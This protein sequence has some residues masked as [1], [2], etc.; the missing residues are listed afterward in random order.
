MSRLT[1]LALA[2]LVLL[3]LSVVFAGGDT[4]KQRFKSNMRSEDS[5]VRYEA[6]RKLDTNDPDAVKAIVKVLK[7]MDPRVT[8]S[9]IRSG[10]VESL[11]KA[12]SEDSLKLILK[13]MAKGKTP[14]REVMTAAIGR[15]KDPAY[16][17]ALRGALNDKQPIVRRAA[18]RAL[19]GMKDKEAI[20]A[21]LD[22]WAKEKRKKSFREWALCKTS[23]E[24]MTGKFISSFPVDWRNWWEVYR[25]PFSFEEEW[26]DEDKAR[27][28]REKAEEE[29]RK[30][31][32]RK[33]R[34]RSVDLSIKIRG[35]GAPILVLPMGGYDQAYY[36]PYLQSIQ[37]ICKIHYV[38]LPA[39]KEFKGLE[40]GAGGIVKYPMD[41][42]VDAFEDLRK[43]LKYKKFA[44]MGHETTSM[45]AQRY[46]TKYPDSVSHLI[47]VG[48]YSGTEAYR[49][50]LKAMIATGKK[51]KDSELEYL[52]LSILVDQD[53]KQLREPR[54]SDEAESLSRR[55][56]A[57]YFHYPHDLI[58][59]EMYD[60]YRL[61]AGV[62]N[63]FPEFDT[64]KE[65][66]ATVPTLVMNGRHSLWS[67]V[68]DAQKIAKHYRNS[69]L[70]IFEKS[71]MM[72]FIEETEK[73]A[74]HIHAFF[75]KYPY[76]KK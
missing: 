24:E 42:L 56:F 3:P 55:S 16:L 33:S 2:V 39:I 61:K 51:N 57:L 32:E 48:A 41:E 11:S 54:D 26:E 28:E 18:I 64:F 17:D 74:A 34:T 43:D 47:L 40:R 14:V 5:S 71:T 6:V 70:V 66:R 73:F 68:T 23:L 7:M 38:T 75:K 76:R 62:S 45:V 60:E 59:R 25:E 29:G 44:I 27:E 63:Y 9:R 20:D 4:W 12:T 15:K 37:D 72:P 1:R 53:G 30:A 46:V 19:A 52:P 22:R 58:V 21:I 50:I 31:A 69:Q 8:N 10:A 65:R 35:A 67:N 49:R 36:E 13:E